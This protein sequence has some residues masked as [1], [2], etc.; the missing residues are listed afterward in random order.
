[1]LVLM[2]VIVIVLVHCFGGR[3]QPL[4]I[5]SFF[6]NGRLESHGEENA[7]GAGSE[8]EGTVGTGGA[9]DSGTQIRLG[10]SESSSVWHLSQRFVSQRWTLAR[11]PISENS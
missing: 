10:S 5:L 4:Q 9:G 3:R 8:G 11:D 2:H 1:M 7:R 6:E